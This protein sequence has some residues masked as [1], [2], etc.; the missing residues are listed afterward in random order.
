M[1]EQISFDPD[2]L[3]ESIDNIVREE[4]KRS[5]DEEYNHY[6]KPIKSLHEGYGYAAERFTAI[7]FA[8]KQ[9]KSK[10]A[11]FLSSLSVQ[12]LSVVRNILDNI[13]IFSREAAKA[14]I[15]LAVITQRINTEI[16][17]ESLPPE[18]YGENAT[19]NDIV[20]EETE[21]EPTAEE[22]EDESTAE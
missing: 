6:I 9:I 19:E 22:T 11:D 16:N 15:R 18:A 21:D 7:A 8:D 1:Y 17:L 14:A 2:F 3:G 13:F 10:V 20:Y 12:D 4:F 5:T